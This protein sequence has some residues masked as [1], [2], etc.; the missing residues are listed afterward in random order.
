IRKAGF[1]PKNIKYIIITQGH[2]DHFG[3]AARIKELSGARVATAEG[4]WRIMADYEQHLMP[5]LPVQRVPKR[6]MVLKDGDHITLGP[7]TMTVYET[8]GHTPGVVSLEFTV[9]DNGV[10]HKAFVFGGPEPVANLGIQGAEQFLASV[11]RIARIPN[12]EV[13]LLV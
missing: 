2:L 8:P 1:D 7:T 11:N 5:N 4:D 12:I 6:D 9:F 3:G 10:P 13:G